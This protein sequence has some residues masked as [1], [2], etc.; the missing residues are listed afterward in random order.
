MKKTQNSKLKIQN[1]IVAITGA[2]G[3]LYAERLLKALLEGGHLIELIVSENSHD[4][5]KFELGL[6]S[7]ESVTEFLKRKY[8]AEI[9]KG[10]IRIHNPNNLAAPPSSGTHAHNGMV[11]IPCSMKTLSSVAVGASRNLIERSADVCLKERRKLILVTRETPFSR[12]HLENMLR[13]TDAGGIVMPC[14]PGFYI[15]PKKIEDLAD[16]IAGKVMN[17]LGLE[18]KL[19]KPWGGK[20]Q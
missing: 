3:M 11:I 19:F 17:L 4:L 2:S 1:L 20:K 12:I 6:K 7:N 18:H 13:V 10:K 16:F 15:R 9:F 14:D 5:L 8:G